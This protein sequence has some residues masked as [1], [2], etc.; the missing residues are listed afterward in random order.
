MIRI[1]QITLRLLAFI[2]FINNIASGQGLNQETNEKF[3][4]SIGA[5]AGFTTGYG[6]S[7]RFMP[8]KFGGQINFAPFHNDEIDRY[9]AGLSLLY[10][11]IES[12]TSSFYLY[13]GN[14]YFYNSQ[15]VYYW[16]PKDPEPFPIPE[17]MYYKRRTTEAYFNNGLGIGI[18]FVLLERIGFNIMAGYAFYRNFEQLN[19]TGETGLYYKF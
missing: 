8:G 16:E 17:P 6:L 14:H 4:H 7:Y 2:F 13:Q 9:S 18:E 1:I 3:K 11:L 10:V 15:M 5:G 19:F 12:R